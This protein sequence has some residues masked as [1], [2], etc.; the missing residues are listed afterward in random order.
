MNPVQ[1]S[2][3]RS[4]IQI[5]ISEFRDVRNAVP[6]ST[7]QAMAL[8]VLA[9]SIRDVIDELRQVNVELHELN[10]TVKDI[11]GTI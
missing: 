1:L 7:D 10:S 9:A 11:R 5:V 3:L 4:N 2:N 6:T 8:L